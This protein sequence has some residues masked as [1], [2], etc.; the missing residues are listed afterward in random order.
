MSQQEAERSKYVV[1]KAEQAS[2]NPTDMG[3]VGSEQPTTE[4]EQQRRDTPLSVAT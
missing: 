3:N 4:R 1:L 2:W